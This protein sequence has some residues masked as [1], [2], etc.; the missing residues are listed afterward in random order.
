MRDFVTNSRFTS[1]SCNWHV[2]SLVC[3]YEYKIG[4]FGFGYFRFQ[5]RLVLL[6]VFFVK[7]IVQQLLSRNRIK[8]NEQ[9]LALH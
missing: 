2:V 9:G 5:I 4:T 1:S 8:T 6:L 7:N 3:L